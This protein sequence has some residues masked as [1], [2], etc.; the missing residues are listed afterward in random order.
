MS[1]NIYT[2]KPSRVLFI[3]ETYLKNVTEI[4]D[5][6]D[7]KM[8]RFSIQANQDKFML[9]LLGNNIFESMKQ[10]IASGATLSGNPSAFLSN[11]YLYILEDWVQPC[12]AC[13]C[14]IELVYKINLQIRN[15]G[16]MQAHSEL[17]TN[18]TDKQ[19]DW[20]SENYRETAAFYAQR[21]TQ[22]LVS[23]PDVYTNYLNPQLGTTGNGADLF[24]P[25]R[26][27]YFAGIHLP[28]MQ[29]NNPAT[30]GEYVG[31]GM[32]VNQRMQFLGLE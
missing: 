1:F 4:S 19:I 31:Y 16:I 32:S 22:F 30:A 21:L 23:N 28:G 9:P 17:S 2:P 15:K 20:L 25:Q 7:P 29:T 8:I 13:A 27:Q 5:N 12:L 3:D 26:T 11:D 18:A 6:V 24:Y 10:Q 14:M